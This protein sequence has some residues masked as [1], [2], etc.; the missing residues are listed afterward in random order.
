MVKLNPEGILKAL[1]R[2]NKLGEEIERKDE[3]LRGK[4]SEIVRELNLEAEPISFASAIR[5]YIGSHKTPN[6]EDFIKQLE[7]YIEKHIESF[8]E[9]E[10]EEDENVAEDIARLE[11]LKSR[12]GEVVKS[13]WTLIENP[14]KE[15][16]KLNNE[17][18]ELKRVKHELFGIDFGDVITL[19]NLVTLVYKCLRYAMTE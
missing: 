10:D 6:L 18:K 9:E 12:I 8:T 7:G 5:S 2:Y 19:E 17:I 13:K 11:R 15:A 14:L 1:E 16:I 3:E 4:I